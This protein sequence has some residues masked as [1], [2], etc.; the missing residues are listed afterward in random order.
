LE[1]NGFSLLLPVAVSS[2]GILN[3]GISEEGRVLTLF[4]TGGGRSESPEAHR[5]TV[6]GVESEILEV[7]VV[8]GVE[9]V[10]RIRAR[11]GE[12][13]ERR[14]IWTASGIGSPEVTLPENLGE[15][16]GPVI[17]DCA[18]SVAPQRLRTP[19]RKGNGKGRKSF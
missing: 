9:G 14:V 16:A 18:G 13:G 4:G 8:A 12:A 19:A 11:A 10:Y 3:A 5:V 1:I 7:A 17:P 2:P 6:N 15:A